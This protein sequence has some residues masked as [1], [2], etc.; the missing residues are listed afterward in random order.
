MLL[1]QR[2][3]TATSLAV[4]AWGVSAPHQ[5]GEGTRDGFPELLYKPFASTSLL[6]VRGRASTTQFGYPS[7]IAPVKVF[8]FGGG[9]W[10]S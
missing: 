4:L 7:L 6:C 3:V 9:I 1:L 5:F 8:R 10:R 2:Q